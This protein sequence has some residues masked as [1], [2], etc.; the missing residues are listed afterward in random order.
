[1]SFRLTC[2]DC[3]K[4]HVNEFTFHG[5]L[6]ER[7][8]PDA[9]FDRWVHY[10]RRAVNR[11]GMQVEWWRHASGCGRWFLVHRDTGDNTRHESFRVGEAPRPPGG[12]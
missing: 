8:A 4:R 7:P 1:M 5:E 11:H 12:G 9:P 6:R 10:V 2:P 3:G